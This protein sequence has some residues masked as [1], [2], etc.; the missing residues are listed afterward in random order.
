MALQL[1]AKTFDALENLS[2]EIEQ[3]EAYNESDDEEEEEE[4]NLVKSKRK[5]GKAKVFD[6]VATFE[7]YLTAKEALINDNS[8]SNGMKWR[9]SATKMT[10]K[11]KEEIILVLTDVSIIDLYYNFIFD[12]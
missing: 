8:L 4:I 3:L 7:D 11:V 2:I 12:K 1:L 9:P 5:R 6:L 10:K